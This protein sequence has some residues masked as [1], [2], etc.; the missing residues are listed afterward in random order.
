MHEARLRHDVPMAEEGLHVHIQSLLQRPLAPRRSA[1][2]RTN[3]IVRQ[4]MVRVQ[5]ATMRNRMQLRPRSGRHLGSLRG[6]GRKTS[7]RRCGDSTSTLWVAHRSDPRSPDPTARQSGSRETSRGLERG[8][9]GKLRSHEQLNEKDEAADR[10]KPF[11]PL[12]KI[13]SGWHC[14]GVPMMD[15]RRR[16]ESHCTKTWCHETDEKQNG[17]DIL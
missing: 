4:V 14:V 6:D 8:G 16:K 13:G 12:T 10:L 11:V 1:Q 9:C 2:K 7:A 3:S 15:V 5:E 17:G